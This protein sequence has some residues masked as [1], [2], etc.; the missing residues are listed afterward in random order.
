MDTGIHNVVEDRDPVKLVIWDMDNTLWSGTLSE[1]DNVELR[2]GAA[3]ILDVLDKKGVLLSIASRNNHDDVIAQL[4]QFGLA[5]FFITPEI[6]WG[7]KSASVE[8]IL[9]RLGIN[10]KAAIFIDDSAFERDEVR[11]RF[12]DITTID[13]TDMDVLPRLAHQKPSALAAQRRA[14]YQAEQKRQ[15]AE[16]EF[17]GSEEEFLATLKMSLTIRSAGPQDLT[18]AAELTD[19]T[20]QLNATGR[21]YS[22]DELR[23]MIQDAAYEILVAELV[24]RYGDYGI[25]G[26]CVLS[27][28]EKVSKI[29]IILLSCR[30]LN[31][32]ISAVLMNEI[33]ELEKSRGRTVFAEL[34][35]T[36]R[37]RHMELAFRFSGFDISGKEDSGVVLLEH[38][39]QAPWQR[40][41]FLTVSMVVQ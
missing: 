41:D 3:D 1:D 22:V 28:S 4:T 17:D 34:V 6:N 20:N 16:S 40:P 37:N 18:R 27:K 32:G 30:V 8:R 24:D 26:L 10:P 15:E 39:A 19:R 21:R 29:K 9:E 5:D 2:P 7:A 13:A 38:R 23:M 36:G 14:M 11:F 35:R 12:P 33:V 31:R 25:V